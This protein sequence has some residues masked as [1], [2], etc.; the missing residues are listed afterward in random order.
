MKPRKFSGTR[1]RDVLEQVRNELGQDAIIVSNRATVDG[2]EVLAIAGEAMEALLC[3]EPPRGPA[4]TPPQETPARAAPVRHPPR[5]DPAPEARAYEVRAPEPALAA[6]CTALGAGGPD[7][8]TMPRLMGEVAT[9]RRLLEE[10]LG[11]LAWSDLLRRRP[12][13]ARVQRDLLAAGFSAALA[14]DLAQGMPSATTAASARP[15]IASALA[16]RLACVREGDDPLSEGGVFALVGPTGVG[17]TTTVAKLAARAA[18]RAGAAR[19]AQR[20]TPSCRGGAPH[21]HRNNGRLLGKHRQ[22][23][24]EPEDLALALDR[25][26]SRHLVLIDTVGLGQ[27][28]RRVADQRALLADPRIR[29]LLLLN[30]TAQGATLE[31]VLGAYGEGSAR[32]TTILTKLDEAARLAPVVDVAARHSLPIAYVTHGQRVPE[33]LSHPSADVLS[34]RALRVQ[35]AASSP[36]ALEIDEVPLAPDDV[37]SELAH[38]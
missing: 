8:D 27:R 17:K 10:Q 4:D 11:G 25:T 9:L 16:S 35:G 7:A 23:V 38:A 6:P 22:A 21:P 34:D 18:R 15:C 37:S 2:I 32:P 14:R 26:A 1:S 19:R 24:A 33:D 20:T 29:K 30:A 28:D 3:G 12:V 36:F 31:E 13:A 5:L